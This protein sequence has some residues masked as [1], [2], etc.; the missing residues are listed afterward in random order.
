MNKKGMGV[1]QAFVSIVVVLTFGIIMIFGYK[2]IDGFLHSGEDVGFV[3][4]KSDL[5][6]DVKRIYTE[7][8]SVR[9]KS[10][11]LPA[12]YEQICFVDMDYGDDP[13]ELAKIDAERALLCQE[14]ILACSIWEDAQPGPTGSVSSYGGVSS[15]GG[16]S[17][18]GVGLSGVEQNVFLTPDA[19]SIKV[20]SIKIGQK[21]DTD[22]NIILG[23][24]NRGYLCLKIR[25]GKFTLRLEGKG[26]HTKISEGS[27]E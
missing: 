4:F 24:E 18:S 21:L 5:E 13:A 22:G 9:E 3:Q 6:S 15:S 16:A 17:S 10:Y 2:A 20:K 12:K 1:E 14:N 27:V 11:R 8:G 26:D 25:A 23:E 7:Y 19:P